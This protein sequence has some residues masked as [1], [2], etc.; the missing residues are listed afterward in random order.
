M[1]QDYELQKIV[2]KS[3]IKIMH[4]ID[5]EEL[6]KPINQIPSEEHKKFEKNY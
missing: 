2:S 4:T 5:T 3:L 6:E 1:D